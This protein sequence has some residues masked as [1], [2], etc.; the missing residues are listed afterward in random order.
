MSRTIADASRDY[1]NRRKERMERYERAL[2]DI[3]ALYHETCDKM[4]TPKDAVVQMNDIA[5]KAL[6]PDW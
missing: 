3:V 6:N 5:D 4:C 2:N 1:R